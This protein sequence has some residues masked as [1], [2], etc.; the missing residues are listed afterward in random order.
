MLNML[1]VESLPLKIARRS[2]LLIALLLLL[3]QN[4]LAKEGPNEFA[5]WL[6]QLRADALSAHQD[7]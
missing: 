7:Q 3:S 6:D 1:Y 2:L 5:V 4:V